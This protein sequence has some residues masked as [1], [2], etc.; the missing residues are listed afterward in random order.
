MSTLM[1][2]SYWIREMIFYLSFG[3][4]TYIYLTCIIK[5]KFLQYWVPYIKVDELTVIVKRLSCVRSIYI[6]PDKMDFTLRSLHCITSVMPLCMATLKARTHQCS[7]IDVEDTSS[8]EKC[9]NNVRDPEKKDPIPWILLWYW[10]LEP[11][12]HSRAFHSHSSEMSFM[13]QICHQVG[14]PIMTQHILWV[15]Y[16]Y[17]RSLAYFATCQ[18]FTCWQLI[19][20][21]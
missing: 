14:R 18:L 8:I 5:F 1:S 3:N 7:Y 16:W 11:R 12:S 21:H 9:T 4:W 19:S 13:F 20:T 6:T 10:N 17:F 15:D 2:T